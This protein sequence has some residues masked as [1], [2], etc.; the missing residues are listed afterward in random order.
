MYTG[1][2][3]EQTDDL[4]IDRFTTI[5]D[6]AEHA[7][8]AHAD[9]P[10]FCCFGHTMSFREVD[11]QS[12][13]LASWLRDHNG[14]KPGDRIAI[15]LPNLLQFPVAVFAAARAGLVVVNTNP[16]Y[17]PREMK[18]QFVDSDVRG[19]I[20]LENFCDKLQSILPETGIT[21][22]LT[23]QVADMLPQPRRF[24]LNAGARYIKRLVPR[25]SIPGAH[26]W[27]DALRLAPAP[28]GAV[29]SGTDVA[30]ILYTGG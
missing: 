19:I 15:Q 11:E 26:K 2:A 18:H 6:M 28:G 20:I 16:L 22:V 21:C 29:D 23:T 27:N 7:F 30:L 3:F 4:N 12:A 5:V 8:K 25:W 14:L 9:R 17:T 1:P 24:L 10:A 13:R